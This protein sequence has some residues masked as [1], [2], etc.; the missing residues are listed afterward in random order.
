MILLLRLILVTAAVTFATAVK[1]QTPAEGDFA[2]RS[3][4]GSYA[5]Q[6]ADGNQFHSAAANKDNVVSGRYIRVTLVIS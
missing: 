4:D 1:R 6:Y 2:D 3:T 5:F